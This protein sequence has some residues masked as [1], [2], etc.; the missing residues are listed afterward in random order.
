MSISAF[1][2]NV[3]RIRTALT[4]PLSGVELA[5]LLKTDP[6]VISRWE[7]GKGGLP[8]APTLLRLAKHLGVSIDALLAGV[9]ADYDE[10]REH[11]VSAVVLQKK[12]PAGSSPVTPPVLHDRLPVQLGSGGS[13]G[14][15]EST[16]AGR[17][18]EQELTGLR[19]KLRAIE[20]RDALAELLDRFAAS[21]DD[22][23]SLAAML[24][25]DPRADPPHRAAAKESR[26]DVS[27]DPRRTRRGRR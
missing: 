7:N 5:K 9:D 6:S 22:V 21:S 15:A 19:A 17:E 13:Y 12:I 25:S 14:G 26:R 16:T 11:P 23:R 10:A 3:K 1:G 8:E 4:P 2:Q 24:R 27:A 20:K 18:E